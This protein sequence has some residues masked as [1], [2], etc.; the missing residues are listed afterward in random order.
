[1]DTCKVDQLI[2]AYVDA[3]RFIQQFWKVFNVNLP[4]MYCNYDLRMSKEFKETWRDIQIQ[5][6]YPLFQ[7][8][9]IDFKVPDGLLNALYLIEVNTIS[10]HPIKIG[11]HGYVNG[12]DYVVVL[13]NAVQTLGYHF[14]EVDDWDSS[15]VFGVAYVFRKE[16]L[17]TDER[18]IEVVANEERPWGNLLDGFERLGKFYYPNRGGTCRLL[19]AIYGLNSADWLLIFAP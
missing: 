4:V 10:D 15:R 16:S 3:D 8:L 17:L 7:T 6:V 12:L 13:Q 1:M 14:Q 2:Q 18:F 11:P 19:R 9:K 5:F